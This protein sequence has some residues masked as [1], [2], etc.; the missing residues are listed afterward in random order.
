MIRAKRISSVSLSMSR[1]H[2]LGVLAGLVSCVLSPAAR[3]ERPAIPL[4][5][6]VIAPGDT[7]AG[8]A[9][10]FYGDGDRWD[11]VHEFNPRLGPELPHRLVPGEVLRLPPTLPPSAWVTR[12]VREVEHRSAAA[13]AWSPSKPGEPLD[14]GFRVAT[15]EQSA[16]RLTFRDA[17]ELELRQETLVVIFGRSAG[18]IDRRPNRARLERGTLMSRLAAL[19]GEGDGLEVQS[20]SAVA[21]FGAGEALMSLDEGASAVSN[22]AGGEVEVASADRSAK[23]A[24]AAGMGTRVEPGRAPAKPRPLPEPPRWVDDRP[25]TAWG[26]AAE[27]AVA[28]VAWAPVPGARRYRIDLDGG[29]S[30]VAGADLPPTQ[31]SLA[32]T[33]LPAGAWT[34][35]VSVTDADALSSRPSAPIALTVAALPAEGAAKVAVGAVIRGCAPDEDPTAPEVTIGAPGPR[36][37]RCGGETRAI[38]AEAAP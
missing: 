23:V 29:E 4:V 14:V 30:L 12:V 20:G 19:R 1:I 8:I 11:V 33:G 32:L 5:D 27:Q 25:R 34:V 3:A 9:R 35:R 10:R 6:H 2:L 28:Q 31:T 17:S 16:A 7:C 37:L 26:L 21:S 15:R 22:H 18:Q 38:V 24:V 13:S 36:T